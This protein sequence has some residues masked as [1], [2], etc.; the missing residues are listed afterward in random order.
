M[1]GGEEREREREREERGEEGVRGD[2]GGR[3]E[4]ADDNV[5]HGTRFSHGED[6]FRRTVKNWNQCLAT[7]LV[8]KLRVLVT[9]ATKK[10]MLDQGRCRHLLHDL[11]DQGHGISS[12]FFR[13]PGSELVELEPVYMSLHAYA[14]QLWCLVP[15]KEIGSDLPLHLPF[16]PERS[17]LVD[18]VGQRPVPSS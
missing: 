15:S 17:Q 2:G 5:H 8:E 9:K 12:G 7:E 10:R 11:S 18:Q 3:G 1:K 13:V 14:Q 16:F 6:H 4:A